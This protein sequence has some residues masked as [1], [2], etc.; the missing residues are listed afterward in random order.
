MAIGRL[1]LP[2][3]PQDVVERVELAMAH[4]WMVRTFVKHAPE[5][6]TFEELMETPRIIFDVVRALETRRDD[7]GELL[8]ML[9]K[10]F[11][12]LRD[13]AAQFARFVDEEMD[14]TNFKQAALSLNG[15]IQELEWI[16]ATASDNSDGA[17][18]ENEP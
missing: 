12:K 6:E 18:N 13:V 10:K 11:S 14:H 8:K 9:R 5:A 3:G 17:L 1:N 4:A 15:C 7:A 2:F 16:L